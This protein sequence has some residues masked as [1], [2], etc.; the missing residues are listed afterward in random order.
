VHNFQ[1]QSQFLAV[2][3]KI[4]IIIFV[5]VNNYAWIVLNRWIVIVGS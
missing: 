4:I 1:S 2:G 5:I 3:P